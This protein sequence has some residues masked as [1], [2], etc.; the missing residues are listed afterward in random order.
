MSEKYVW[1][2]IIILKIMFVIKIIVAYV[3]FIFT[4]MF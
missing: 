1:I 3:N 2:F 4:I